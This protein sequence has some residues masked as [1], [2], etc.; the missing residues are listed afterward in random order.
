MSLTVLF[1]DPVVWHAHWVLSPALG[2]LL[3]G[4]QQRAHQ[5]L[6]ELA[7]SRQ[8]ERA[9]VS[10]AA[11]NADEHQFHHGETR[12]QKSD[13]CC[14]VWGSLMRMKQNVSSNEAAESI[15]DGDDALESTGNEFEMLRTVRNLRQKNREN[16]VSVRN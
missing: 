2:N 10:S 1:A 13:T 4:L 3:P 12:E 7:L 9:A 8:R 6:S 14:G 5:L 16:Q 11:R 15:S